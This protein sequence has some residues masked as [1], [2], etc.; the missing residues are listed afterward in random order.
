MNNTYIPKYSSMTCSDCPSWYVTYCQG[1]IEITD[2]GENSAISVN[3]S[4]QIYSS[5]TINSFYGTLMEAHEGGRLTL[6]LVITGAKEIAGLL[7]F[8]EEEYS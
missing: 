2:F 1:S 5:E 7:N 3:I 4:N 8:E 6:D